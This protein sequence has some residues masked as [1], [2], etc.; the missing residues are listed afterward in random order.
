MTQTIQYPAFPPMSLFVNPTPACPGENITLSA[1]WGYVRYV[2]NFGDGS[3]VD[4]NINA[5]QN[6]VYPSLGTYLASVTMTQ[7]CGNDTTIS[8]TVNINSSVPFPS[9][10]NLYAYPNPACPFE[11]IYLSGIWGYPFYEWNFGDG[12]PIETGTDAFNDHVYTG[13][14][15]YSASLK[16]TNLCGNDTTLINVVNIDNNLPFPGFLN[17]YLSANPACPGN[18]DFNSSSGFQ[19]Y[20]W[21]FGDGSPLLTTTTSTASHVY[22]N[23]G[24]YPISL[25]IVNY[26]GADTTL[27]DTLIVRYTPFPPLYVNYYPASVCPNENVNFNASWGYVSYEWDFGDGNQAV[28]SS[29]ISH[30]YN[31]VGVYLV[32][33]KINQLCG[34]D[35]TL[36]D[37]VRVVNNQ[38]ISSWVYLS[39]FPDPA[40]PAEDINVY[41]AWGYASYE[42]DFGDGYLDTTNNAYVTYNYPT[43]G[44]Y[45]ISLKLINYC[46]LDTVLY[47]SIKVDGNLKIPN[48]VNLYVWYQS[49]SMSACP[50]EMV[51]LDGPW[52]FPSYVWDYGDGTPNDS[53]S[54]QSMSHAYAATGTYTVALTVTNF[55]GN[56]TTLYRSVEIDDNK[57]FGWLSLWPGMGMPWCPGEQ[58]TFNAAQ[59]YAAYVW[60]YGDGSSLDSNT[61]SKVKHAFAG[62][63]TYTVSVKFID[64]CGKDSTMSTMV[65]IDDNVGIWAWINVYPNPI[66]P[67][68]VVN[69]S[70]D[71]SNV[72]YFWDFGDGFSAFGSAQANHSYSSLGNYDVEV[73]ITNHC[74]NDSTFTAIVNVDTTTAFP[75][76]MNYWVEPWDA[77]PGELVTLRTEQGFSNYFWDFG[78]GDTVTTTGPS[79]QHSYD[80]AGTYNAAVTITNGCGN[81]TTLFPMV[82]VNASAIVQAPQIK[83]QFAAYCPGDDVSFLLSSWSAGWQNYTYIWDFGD[84]NVDTTVGVGALHAFDSV[85]NYTTSVTILN[86]CGDAAMVTVPINIINNAA[87]TLNANTFGTLA[88]TNSVGCPGD[89]VVFYFEGTASDNLW[90]FGDGSSGE[91]TEQFMD[92]AG[93]TMT[94][95]KHA[96]S[97]AGSYTV[98]LTLTNSCGNSTQD[99]IT[100]SINSNLLVDGGLILEP[101]ATT[102]RYTTCSSINMIAFG[103]SSYEFDFGDGGTLTTIS[104]SISYVFSTAG[105]YSISVTITNGC[106]NSTTF[107]QSV[108]IE[109]SAGIDAV[110]SIVSNVTCFEGNDGS[111]SVSA[112]GGLSPYIYT[113]DDDNGQTTATAGGL[114]AGIYSV[115][116]SDALGCSSDTNITITEA[117]EIS[118]S[119]STTSANCGLSDGNAMVAIDSG[120]V[121]PFNYTWSSGGSATTEFNLASGSYTVSVTDA[122]GCMATAIAAISDLTG[123]TLVISASSDATCNGDADGALTVSA[124]GGT[125]PYQYNWSNGDSTA[126]ISG[127]IAGNYIVSVTDGSTCMSVITRSVGEPDEM[128]ASFDIVEG[129]CGEA[130]GMATVSATGG[131]P[132]YFYQWDANAGSVVTL[133]ATGLS[134]NA[135]QVT[136]TD[137]NLCTLTAT[138]TV[139]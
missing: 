27:Y 52:G 25:K 90:D 72:S 33:V 112:S 94:V 68:Q 78:D 17:Y 39:A 73:T 102:G 111:A 133:T 37:T 127:L 104:P 108:N 26:C 106:G 60:N 113:W 71:T 100:I 105:N 120:G 76:W 99:S 20:T 125:S 42:W 69:F 75:S 122:N 29:Y 11:S 47:D 129:E 67:G 79:I 92:E 115:T 4:T 45:Q 77:C 80:V 96:Y 131:T 123:P 19:F 14:G 130:T 8:A 55:C 114:E 18:V 97:A 84:G 23:L 46:G 66:C 58:V 24:T 2:W 87:P 88:S 16:M 49:G 56:D 22:P 53:G 136:I 3:P 134:A 119:T 32:S 138:A 124:T 83:T 57:Q 126:A 61:S 107:S 101:P 89:A 110:P 63:G 51:N 36:F 41:G 59:G 54:F 62:A 40:C 34:N 139:G 93:V 82:Y 86:S 132:G 50:S 65:T 81:S 21:D 9:W 116:I 15:T 118:I 64:Y 103:G 7:F 44:D 135:Y 30:K 10:S 74:G 13:V 28:G 137:A 48:W 70:T 35:T 85:G 5:F 121:A 128:D 6:H 1:P 109:E 31:S 98:K 117:L 43:V 95:I 12:T 38:P 91:A